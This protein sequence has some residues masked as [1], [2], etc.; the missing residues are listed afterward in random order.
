M[1][2]L[3]DTN[4]ALNRIANGI[5]AIV[6]QLE[7]IN[8]PDADRDW[9]RWNYHHSKRITCILEVLK[10]YTAEGNVEKIEEYKKDLARVKAE[11]YSSDE[12]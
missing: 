4:S 5:E 7:L 6:E 3:Y 9:D 10:M 11:S 2:D 8:T 12:L 1:N